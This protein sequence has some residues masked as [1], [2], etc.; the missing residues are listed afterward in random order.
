MHP[1]A[2]IKRTDFLGFFLKKKHI[3]HQGSV[4][5]AVNKPQA[6]RLLPLGL[7]SF[8]AMSELGNLWSPLVFKPCFEQGAV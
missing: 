8:A 4:G 3:P 2:L 6:A 5:K 1:E 7:A